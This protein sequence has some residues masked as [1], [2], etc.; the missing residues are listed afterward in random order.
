MRASLGIGPYRHAVRA[1]ARR[2]GLGHLG[3]VGRVYRDFHMG[4]GTAGL[5]LDH[6]Q[7][8][9]R[10]PS[11]GPTLPHERP[12]PRRADYVSVLR[13][14]TVPA[15]AICVYLSAV[16]IASYGVQESFYIVCLR[17]SG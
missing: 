5:L 11:A 4:A 8:R 16:R 17:K 3:T 15:I 12:D 6:A 2:L 7:H 1:A 9:I 10:R 14:M 13:M